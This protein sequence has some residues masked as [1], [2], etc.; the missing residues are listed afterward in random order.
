M[1]NTEKYKS[2][3]EK[4]GKI[5]KQIAKWD[6]IREYADKKRWKLIYIERDLEQERKAIEAKILKEQLT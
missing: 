2:L 5:E 4:L 1:K 6:K 3:T